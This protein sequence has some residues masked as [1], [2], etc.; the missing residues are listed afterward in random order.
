MTQRDST[1]NACEQFEFE[2]QRR[3]QDWVETLDD[4]RRVSQLHIVA[5]SLLI[6]GNQ[7]SDDAQRSS[8]VTICVFISRMMRKPKRIGTLSGSLKSFLPRKDIE[9]KGR[10]TITHALQSESNAILTFDLDWSVP[11]TAQNPSTDVSPLKDL[12]DIVPKRP[13]LTKDHSRLENAPSVIARAT[14]VVAAVMSSG[15]LWKNVLGQFKAFCDVADQLAAVHPYTKMVWGVVT[16]VP[17]VFQMQIEL[18][19]SMNRLFNSLFNFYDIV[20]DLEQETI[21]SLQAKSDLLTRIAQ[22]TLECYYFIVEYGNSGKFTKRAIT[23]VFSVTGDKIK[24]YEDKL[25]ELKDEFYGRVITSTHIVVTRILDVVVELDESHHL[26]DMPYAR[27]ARYDSGKVCL[28]GTREEILDEITTW[29]QSDEHRPVFLLSG[30]AGTG[31]S[32]IA[33]TIAHRFHSLY[34]LG[35]S[36]FFVRGQADHGPDKLFSTIARDLA[37]ID[38]AFRASLWDVVRREKSLRTTPNATLQFQSFLIE[39]VRSLTLT[40]P[41][42]IVIDGLDECGDAKSRRSLLEILTKRMHELPSNFRLL[43]TTRPE[44]D[45][46]IHLAGSKD[47]HLKRIDEIPVASTERDILAYVHARLHDLDV[48]HKL[49]ASKAE[50]IFQWAFVAC[51]FIQEDELGTT[52][53]ERYESIVT[54]GTAFGDAALDTLYQ[55]VLVQIFTTSASSVALIR[56]KAVMAIVL[57]ALKPLSAD[58]INAMLFP[59]A[60]QGGSPQFDSLAVVKFMGSLLSGVDG[61]TTPIRSRHTSFRDF[62]LDEGRSGKFFVDTGPTHAELARSTLDIMKDGLKFNICQLESSYALNKDV[63]GLQ[64]RVARFIPPSLWY[65]CRFWADHLHGSV[66]TE[67]HYEDV[68]EFMTERLLFWLEVMSLTG[69]VPALSPILS[70]VVLWSQ[71]AKP[72][73][74]SLVYEYACSCQRFL[75]VNGMVIAQSAPHIYLSVLPFTPK[76]CFI[77]S[78]Y[79]HKSPH[80]VRIASRQES[81][82][83]LVQ[84]VLQGHTDTILSLA[85]SPDGNIIA[86][87]SDDF[88]IRLWDATTGSPVFEPLRGH[89]GGVHCVV[90]SPN[91]RTLASSSDDKTVRLWDMINGEPLG[92]PLREHTGFVNSVAFSPSGNILASAS[93]DETIRLWDVAARKS[94]G[95]PWHGHSMAVTSVSFSTNGKVIASASYDT[96]IRLWNATNGELARPPL[97][98]HTMPISS[99][100]FSQNGQH[101]AS[102]AFDDLII[103]WDVT[104]WIPVRSINTHHTQPVIAFSPDGSRLASGTHHEEISVWDVGSGDMIG[105]P[106]QGH[107]GTIFSLTFS[108]DGSRIVS[109][110]Y[111]QTIRLWNAGEVEKRNNPILGHTGSVN[112]IAF[113]PDGTRIVSG[114]FDET[115]RVWSAETG[116]QI[117]EPMRGHSKAVM[118]VAYSPRGDLVASGAYDDLII[119]WSA[120]CLEMVGQPVVEHTGSVNALSF[121]PDGR[122]LASGSDDGTVRLWDTRTRKAF[123]NP[124]VGHTKPVTSVAFSPDGKFVASG[125]FD[126]TIR[127]WDPTSGTSGDALQGATAAITCL[128]YSFNNHYL[129]SGLHDGSVRIWDVKTKAL[130]A[131]P[132]QPHRIVV[133]SVAL[134]PDGTTLVSSSF[135]ETVRVSTINPEQGHS[136][137]V[138]VQGHSRAVFSVMFSPD[139]STVATGSYDRTIRLWD[140]SSSDTTTPSPI[141]FSSSP[142]HTLSDVELLFPPSIPLPIDRD[143]R[144]CMKLTEDGWIVG[145]KDALLLWIPPEHRA[146]LW[147]PRMV[148]ILGAEPTELDLNG[149]AHGA[150]W[151]KCWER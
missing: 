43:V 62:L 67:A 116:R 50:G 34:R 58:S 86:S 29:I 57:T 109:G 37:D 148:R 98:A 11:V 49:L 149:F 123:T 93:Y 32:A 16:L 30:G 76:S 89:Q 45:I 31:K 103:L 82:W 112:C 121:S 136:T 15:S 59:P 22:Q 3:K 65:S 150:Q 143:R 140:A 25:K 138:P 73:F 53:E 115:V 129:V 134:S 131:N 72:Y 1:R 75:S 69:A 66:P 108:P 42:I 146:L 117:G 4:K 114:S 18:D 144:D 130:V 81:D 87:S 26:D 21:D 127:L 80:S 102:A 8:Q 54:S 122:W 36:F 94:I 85:F 133:T 119:F 14:P 61:R 10:Y 78:C 6:G 79:L 52:V 56:F 141:A 19:Q 91:G 142:T 35:S 38:P 51:E 125:S 71:V 13:S 2:D 135:D 64:E 132:L 137:G 106:F 92:K 9:Q 126:M 147:M 46:E 40:G 23:N 12:E 63:P 44:A 105:E 48:D 17:K 118:T 107:A 96:T 77:S 120:D 151:S 55:Q 20:N 97:R 83:P 128:S 88:T 68:R 100:L 111:D 39:S 24:E 41:I 145:P 33:H 104:T 113:S 124:F 95:K 28:P 60:V 5:F 84:S 99:V 90:F 27:G 70:L 47:V 101:M 139:G 74:G 110:S 7:A